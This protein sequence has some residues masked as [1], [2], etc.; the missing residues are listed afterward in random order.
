[1]L[2]WDIAYCSLIGICNLVVIR[3]VRVLGLRTGMLS[4]FADPLLRWAVAFGIL[5]FFAGGVAH[6]TVDFNPD[7]GSPINWLLAL[8]FPLIMAFF[9]P[10]SRVEIAHMMDITGI[11]AMQRCVNRFPEVFGSPPWETVPPEALQHLRIDPEYCRAETHLRA[12]FDTAVLIG[13]RANAARAIVEQAKLHARTRH[14]QKAAA[15]TQEALKFCEA[16]YS[17]DQADSHSA[18]MYADSLCWRGAFLAFGENDTAEGSTL[19]KAAKDL[20]VQID[21]PEGI[22]AVERILL[23]VP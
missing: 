16:Y 9:L 22:A 23:H 18:E 20:Y 8:G 21:C 12:A 5:V 14:W 13:D 1:M 17:R 15:T 2:T 10:F 3:R 11:E 4:G 19:M 6:R 7:F